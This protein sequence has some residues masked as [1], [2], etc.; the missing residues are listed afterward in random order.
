[1]YMYS[2]MEW[3]KKRDQSIDCLNRYVRPMIIASFNLDTGYVVDA[4][5]NTTNIDDL[6]SIND[7]R[8]AHWFYQRLSL[9]VYFKDLFYMKIK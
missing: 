5:T 4:I 3:C 6:T 1:M 2:A 9:N 7:T 8:W